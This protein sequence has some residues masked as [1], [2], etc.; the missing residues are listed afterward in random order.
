M[1]EGLKYWIVWT[2]AQVFRYW[3]LVLPG[4]VVLMVM[5]TD[6]DSP[7][8]KFEREAGCMYDYN[9]KYVKDDER[10]IF[11]VRQLKG[12]CYGDPCEYKYYGYPPKQN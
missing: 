5:T 8:S 2:V 12:L 6:L 7:K 9:C 3:Y 11:L 10:R 1:W 4:L